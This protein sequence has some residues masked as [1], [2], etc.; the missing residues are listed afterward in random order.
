MHL[1]EKSYS[2]DL[3][4]LKTL[5]RT[6]L[7]STDP[8]QGLTHF[9]FGEEGIARTKGVVGRNVIYCLQDCL[10]SFENPETK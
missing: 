3:R 10:G 8:H 5:S 2:E 4:G 6:F 1:R 7:E 9:R